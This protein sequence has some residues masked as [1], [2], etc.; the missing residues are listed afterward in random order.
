MQVHPKGA[1]MQGVVF[2]SYG[3]ANALALSSIPKPSVTKPDQIVIKVHAAALNPIDKIR[4]A[5]GLK[6]FSPERVLPTV[7]GYDAAG[8]VEEVGADAGKKFKVCCLPNCVTT[9]S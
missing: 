5:G 3:D 9:A 7:L 2:V 6:R 4:L 8:V 1:E